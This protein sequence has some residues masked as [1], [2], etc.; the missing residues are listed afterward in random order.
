MHKQEQSNNNK[1]EEYKE[2]E[3]Y[4]NYKV[5]CARVY[6]AKDSNRLPRLNLQLANSNKTNT[7]Q[8]N[9]VFAKQEDNNKAT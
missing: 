3:E 2:V 9:L 6:L 1:E 4:Q 7:D 5:I 8:A